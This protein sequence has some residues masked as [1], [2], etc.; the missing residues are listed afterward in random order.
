[1][2]PELLQEPIMA[3]VPDISRMIGGE[4]SHMNIEYPESDGEPMGET[5]FHVDAIMHLYSALRHLFRDDP[6]VYVA[7]DMFLY[8]EKD[9]PY[10]NKAPDVMVIKGVSKHKRRIFKIWEEGAT[11]CV[12]FEITSDSTK[13]EDLCDKYALY[14]S[15]GVREY[16]LFDPLREHMISGLRGFRLTG[17]MYELILPADR[18]RM[19]SQELGI[20]LRPKGDLLRAIDP[21]TG[22]PVLGHIESLLSAKQAE[23]RAEQEAARAERLTAKLRELGISLD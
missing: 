14:A 15:L 20:W 5:E 4:Y 16:F 11:P 8:Y 22:K 1:M 18:R 2:M 12:I 10:A 19:F 23:I 9:N 17:G 13:D 21:E 7:A 3:E 6:S